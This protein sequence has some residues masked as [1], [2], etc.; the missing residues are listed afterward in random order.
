[1]QKYTAFYTESGYLPLT[2][3]AR[4]ELSHQTKNHFKVYIAW[5]L[6]YDNY[7]V[8]FLLLPSHTRVIK[9]IHGLSKNSNLG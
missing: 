7:L 2:H 3:S 8:N 4:R 5:K 9:N 6:S 1:M